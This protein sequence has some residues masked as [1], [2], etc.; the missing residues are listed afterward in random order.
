MTDA[1]KTAKRRLDVALVERGLAQSRSQ[2][3][4][5]IMA[6]D[7]LVN[8]AAAPHASNTIRASDQVE[9]K[10]KP[11]FVSRGGEKMSAALDAFGIDASGSVCV[12]LGA[13]TGGFTDCL[14]QAGA[15]KVY[16]IDV[17]HGQLDDR[18]RRDERVISMERVN[19]RHLEE[20]PELV[21]IA[22]IDVSF[23]SLKL[24]L[25]VAHRL[26]QDEGLCIP[27]IK[28]QFEAG[29]GQVG[30]GGVVRDPEVHR[31]VLREILGFAAEHRFAVEGLIA[32][33]ILGP[34]G[35]RE[36][37]AQLVKHPSSS[38]DIESMIEKV[39]GPA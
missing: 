1:G 35:N 7:V 22:V 21:S 37:L 25:P 11:R 24:I 32:S 31:S 29:K 14:L 3:Q 30:K 38:T 36:F 16:A 9:L 19:A 8:G 27:L 26:L 12:D 13:S 33:P 23:I 10:A 15:A 5:I 20:L 2:A 34:A 28:P 6:G 39:L 4:A 18:L 17:G